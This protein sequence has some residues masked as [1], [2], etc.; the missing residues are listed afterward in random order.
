MRKRIDPQ[1]A[2]VRCPRKGT[3]GAEISVVIC[4]Q[5][6]ERKPALCQEHHCNKAVIGKEKIRV[7]QLFS[8]E[9]MGASYSSLLKKAKEEENKEEKSFDY[10]GE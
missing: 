5:L 9:S 7:L 2:S 6:Y 8:E 4:G 3:M 1:A 10:L